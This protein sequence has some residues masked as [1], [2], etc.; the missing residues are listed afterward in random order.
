MIT[1]AFGHM[2]GWMLS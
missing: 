1:P 2:E